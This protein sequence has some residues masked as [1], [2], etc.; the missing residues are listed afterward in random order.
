VIASRA[1]HSFDSVALTAKKSSLQQ[2][3]PMSKQI[4]FRAPAGD[5]DVCATE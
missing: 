4:Y 2:R 1:L 5:I 3:L